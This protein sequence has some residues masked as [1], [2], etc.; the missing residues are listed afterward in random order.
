MRV[1]EFGWMRSE[2]HT[3][4]TVDKE[5]NIKLYI[6][7]PPGKTE[8]PPLRTAMDVRKIETAKKKINMDECQ[9]RKNTFSTKKDDTTKA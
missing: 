2:Q 9:N 4:K 3:S 7:E 5:T 8:R 6:Q 1:C